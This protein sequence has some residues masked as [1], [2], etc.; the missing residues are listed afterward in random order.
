MQQRANSEITPAARKERLR[1]EAETLGFSLFGVAP[2][3]EIQT[4][5]QF[6]RFIAEQRH[7]DMA[8]LARTLEKRLDARRVLDKAKSVV[9]LGLNYHQPP[10]P[11]R[12]RIAQY[13]LG[14]DYHNVLYRRLKKLCKVL[15]EW[16]GVSRPYVD[17]G[18]VA[19]KPTAMR[20]GLGWQG[21]HTNLLNAR[22]GNFFVLGV[23]LTTHELLPD[24]PVK[25]RCGTCTRCIEICPT[26]AI[27]GPYQLDARLCISYLTIEHRGPIPEHLRPLL[28][29]HLFGCDDCL[30]VCPWNKWA[31]RT[32]EAAF[33]PR[34]Y[35]D[36]RELLS[37]SEETF[38]E[39]F[40]GSPIKRT[41]RAR[42]LRNACVVLGNI[43][44]EADLPSLHRAASAEDELVAEHARWA[45]GR[46]EG[47]RTPSTPS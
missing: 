4:A 40:T 47:R 7:G 18:P 3:E 25:D 44:T 11:R 10:P 37:L 34:E 24:Q 35:P 32:R 29:D 5:A 17:A 46:I 9:C 26:R 13:A 14:R 30:D 2:A 20:A 23:I 28:G 43:G 27:T 19:E 36:P 16:G 15:A 21:K 42:L 33:D 41:G 39:L 38:A 22:A 12:G 31:Q 1:A 6:R 45:I 8:W